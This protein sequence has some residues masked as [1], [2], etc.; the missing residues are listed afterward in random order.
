[1]Q[2]ASLFA[3]RAGVR[4]DLTTEEISLAGKTWWQAQ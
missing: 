3:I 1:M 4:D 2:F